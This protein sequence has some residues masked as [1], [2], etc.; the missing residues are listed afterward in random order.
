M[1]R[2]ELNDV[3][4]L[5]S[6]REFFNLN[7]EVFKP[8]EPILKAVK[9]QDDSIVEIDGLKETQAT[10]TK[11]EYE[12]KSKERTMLDVKV[13]KVAAGITAVAAAT[14]DIKLRAV[15]D[16]GK[17]GLGR[18]REGDYTTRV[19]AI[20]AAGRPIVAQLAMWGV[21]EADLDSIEQEESQL[22]KKVPVL[23]NQGIVVTQASKDMRKKIAASKKELSTTMDALM[24]PFQNLNPTLYA[25]YKSARKLVTRSAS[26]KK[27]DD[28]KPTE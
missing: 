24:L 5:K 10:D 11:S 15:A 16:L 7:S 27:T 13:L 6:V 3:N 14:S 23:H 20:V 28:A 8:Y 2:K 4:M 19:K 22:S 17:T 1:N 21:T 12:I 18:L 9:D 26:H 25:Q